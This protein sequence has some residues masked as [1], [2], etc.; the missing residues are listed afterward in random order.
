MKRQV[1]E[2]KLITTPPKRDDTLESSST[3]KEINLYKVIRTQLDNEEHPIRK[4]INK[5]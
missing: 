5:F 2:N 3:S 1:T 4:I